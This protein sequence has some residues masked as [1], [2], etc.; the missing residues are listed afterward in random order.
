MLTQDE[1]IEKYNIKEL[2]PPKAKE[3]TREYLN[4]ISKRFEFDLAYVDLDKIISEFAQS[5]FLE[6]HCYQLYEMIS[7]YPLECSDTYKDGAI[8]DYVFRDDDK[9]DI[10][11]LLV[12]LVSSY[13]VLLLRIPFLGVLI[14]IGVEFTKYSELYYAHEREDGES[15]SFYQKVFEFLYKLMEGYKKQTE[16]QTALNVEISYIPGGKGAK[17]AQKN[18]ER[19][20]SDNI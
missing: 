6:K 19:L 1:F 10:E 12:E 11:N 2:L 4:D 3:W 18:F 5:E 8:P 15:R 17:K 20:V 14:S 13:D 9:N 16:L 7:K